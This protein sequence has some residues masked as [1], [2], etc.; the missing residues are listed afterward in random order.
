MHSRYL[1]WVED[2]EGGFEEKPR[3]L[4]FKNGRV[5]EGLLVTVAQVGFSRSE[6]FGNQRDFCKQVVEAEDRLWISQGILIRLISSE[7]SYKKK[8]M[9]GISICLCSV[10]LLSNIQHIVIKVLSFNYEIER[11]T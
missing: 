6:G 4:S 8:K 11:E 3:G 9:L 1:S 10:T 5:L 7:G 2:S